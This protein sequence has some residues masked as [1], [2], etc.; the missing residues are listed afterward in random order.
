MLWVHWLN[1]Q[2][3]IR[4]VSTPSRK[5]DSYQADLICCSRLQ[6]LVVEKF[7]LC[8]KMLLLFQSVL[9]WSEWEMEM[10]IAKKNHFFQS[11]LMLSGCLIKITRGK[12]YNDH[13]PKWILMLVNGKA[14][15]SSPVGMMFYLGSYSNMLDCN[16]VRF[17]LMLN[18][19][20]TS[21]FEIPAVARETGA[22]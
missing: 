7:L 10:N 4:N 17:L 1:H 2:Y 9:T 11:D 14:T 8:K 20:K 15:I 12:L 3:D 22:G 21:G 18:C 19:H 5:C 13:Y 16:L 6:I